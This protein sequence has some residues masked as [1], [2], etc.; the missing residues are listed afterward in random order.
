ME[1]LSSRRIPGMRTAKFYTIAGTCAVLQ[2]GYTDGN[3]Y[4]Y[5][6]HDIGKRW[7]VVQ[8]ETGKI[9]LAERT[10]GKAKSTAESKKIRNKL[11]DA[12]GTEEYINDCSLYDSAVREQIERENFS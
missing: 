12:Y 10:I 5:D 2:S 8:P 4:Y 6:S 7:H 1:N 11:K 3:F 9:I